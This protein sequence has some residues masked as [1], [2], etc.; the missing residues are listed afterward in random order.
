MPLDAEALRGKAEEWGEVIPEAVRCGW[1]R[2]EWTDQQ[3]GLRGAEGTGTRF[4]LVTPQP[5]GQL[6]NVMTLNQWGQ[7]PDALPS[8]K[9]RSCLATF[10]ESQLPAPQWRYQC[11]VNG[12]R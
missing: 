5:D 12:V 6:A 9:S 7:L 11:L 2:W 1:Q 10:A 4:R 3:T 8:G